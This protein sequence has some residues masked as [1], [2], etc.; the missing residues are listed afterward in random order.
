[1]AI[2]LQKI[3]A[4][5]S[6]PDPQIQ[7]F[8]LMSITRLTPQLVDRQEE[9]RGIYTRLQELVAADN[10]D[11]VFLA[12]K[13]CNHVDSY[14]EVEKYAEG[15]RSSQNPADMSREELLAVL[16]A[17]KVEE[18][19]LSSVVSEFLR[20]GLPEDLP[21]LER[22]LAH[23]NAR[24]RANAVEVFAA[25]G[26]GSHVP[27]L[28]P[29]LRDKN[30]RA[31]G[32]V[33]LALARLGYDRVSEP[34][35]AMLE[36]SVISMRET[37]VYVLSQL[38]AP[39]VQG[40]L[41]RCL[42]DPYDGI[43]LRAV[44]ALARIPSRE[45][46]MALKRSLNDMDISVCEAA[47]E[48]LR[49]IKALVERRRQAPTPPPPSTTD[50]I[51]SASSASSSD[52]G[53]SVERDGAGSEGEV[54]DVD[55]IEAPAPEAATPPQGSSNAGAEAELIR[56]LGTEIYQLCRNNHLT[57]EE[58]DNVFYEILRYQDF[59]RAY[60]VKKQKGE[61]DEIDGN[62]A[63][64]QLQE[65]IKQSFSLLGR[66]TLELVGQGELEIPTDTG[67]KAIQLLERV[68]QASRKAVTTG[69]GDPCP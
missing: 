68:R 58:L 20:K 48:S 31:R 49:H 8:A 62:R 52:P 35:E 67:G 59:L 30:N 4:D 36:M 65:R 5:L 10:P 61:T 13:A 60:L 12:R 34:I 55:S 18:T 21:R 54:V 14:F 63:I 44:K 47:M 1:M 51:P 24:V 42:A 38:N 40:L 15:A 7:T 39:F 2:N 32:N 9:I 25:K 23:P 56:E 11:V 3:R 57:H 29:L 69:S 37:A 16:E 26:N 22:L 6:H 66:R 43:R 41:I 50:G 19:Y 27:L 64:A 45:T 53:P 46:V 33:I 28:Q 17:P